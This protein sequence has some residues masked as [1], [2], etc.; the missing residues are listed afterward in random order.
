MH[1]HFC[2][3]REKYAENVLISLTAI[4]D[5]VSEELNEETTINIGS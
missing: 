2:D 4:Q 1:H 5:T 3:R